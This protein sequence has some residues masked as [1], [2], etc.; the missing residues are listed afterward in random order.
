[1]QTD[2]LQQHHPD[3]SPNHAN[4]TGPHPNGP[5]H[6][7]LVEPWPDPVDPKLLLDAL[8]RLLRGYVIM[9]KWASDALALFIVHTYAFLLRDVT[10]Y[11][12]IESPQK[13]C[14]KST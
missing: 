5:L 7:P 2:T 4:L 3:T 10:A 14:G 8:V 1:M 13:R 9:S 11:V 6:L 12:G